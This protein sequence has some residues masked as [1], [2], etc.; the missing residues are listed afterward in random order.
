MPLAPPPVIDTN[1]AL[2][3]QPLIRSDMQRAA[4]ITFSCDT[5]GTPS[6]S[7][8]QTTV[9]A[10]FSEFKANFQA[11]F[12]SQ[13][14]LLPPSIKLGAG[15][16]VPYEAVSTGAVALGGRAGSFAP[17]NVAVLYKKT[18]G[19]GGKQN[20]GR[21]YFPFFADVA[22]INENG[23]LATGVQA[24][25]STLGDGFINGLETAGIPMILSHKEFNVPLAPHHVIHVHAGPLVT[26]FACEALIAT[27]RRRLGR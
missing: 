13:V 20:H 8:A 12:D 18:T 17:P 4:Q 25:F 2:I 9:D 22:D 10:F 1:L 21:S 11:T 26:A 6:I 23:T 3:V 27:Q 16:T 15:T 5:T 19:L 24:A 14:S 7:L